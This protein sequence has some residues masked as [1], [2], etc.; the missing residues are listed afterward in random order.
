MA[1]EDAAYLA[2]LLPA[3]SDLA[4][5]FREYE[6]GRESRTALITRRARR[7]GMIG[8]WENPGMVRAR[9]FLTRLVLTLSPSVQLNTVYSYKI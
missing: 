4:A 1:I 8:Q 2:K 6:A 3:A 5:T 9:N 7:I